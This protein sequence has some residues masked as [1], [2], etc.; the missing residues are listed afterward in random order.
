MRLAGVNCL[1]TPAHCLI[2]IATRADPLPHVACYPSGGDFVQNTLTLT[3][4]ASGWTECLVLRMRAQMLVIEAF[5]K[6]AAELPFPML[7]VDSDNDSAF[8]SQSDPTLR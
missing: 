4:I 2:G 3:D 6:V 7:G 1:G 5:D 8:M